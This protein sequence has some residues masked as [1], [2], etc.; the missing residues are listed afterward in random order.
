[1][2]KAIRAPK[3]V[4]RTIRKLI[5]MWATDILAQTEDGTVK[6][7]IAFE[8]DLF[9]GDSLSPLLFCLSVAPLSWELRK[10][11]GFKSIHNPPPL[12][13]THL[14]FMD[15]L[16]L[17]EESREEL[18]EPIRK[19]EK[20]SEQVGMR[21]GLRKCAVAHVREGRVVGGGPA[22]L[23]SGAA[24]AEIAG[25][26]TYGTLAYRSSYSQTTRKCGRWNTWGGSGP[27]GQPD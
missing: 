6:L 16:K 11:K 10:G 5:P 22:K 26:E 12:P 2:L 1:M 17:Y 15:D 13:V 3:P 14:M 27:P 8:R 7:P 4:R 21:L 9:Q 23:D 18:E 20:L 25:E 24:I 19:V